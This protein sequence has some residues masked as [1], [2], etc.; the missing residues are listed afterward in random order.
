MLAA[1]RVISC[2]RR[3]ALA[4]RTGVL[5][6]ASLLAGASLAVLAAGT[7]L[8]GLFG[9]GGLAGYAYFAWWAM[10]LWHG[11]AVPCVQ[12]RRPS[13]KAGTA[14]R[15]VPGSHPPSQQVNAG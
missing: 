7:T 4:K 12:T 8:S 15:P 11:R 6:F 13:S 9:I 14:P 1:M 10:R 5:A 2:A 3:D